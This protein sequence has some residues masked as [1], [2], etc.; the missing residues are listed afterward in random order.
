M[1]GRLII[2]HI[3]DKIPWLHRTILGTKISV[4]IKIYK[5]MLTLLHIGKKAI[6]ICWVSCKRRTW[7]KVF[8]RK[9]M[10]N[11]FIFP[12]EDEVCKKWKE[13]DLCLQSCWTCPTH[14][15]S[16]WN[17]SHFSR[18]FRRTTRQRAAT[19]LFRSYIHTLE[20]VQWLD[21]ISGIQTKGQHDPRGIT[22]K[23]NRCPVLKTHT[24]M[25]CTLEV[26]VT[27]NFIE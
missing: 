5:G 27:R 12:N 24:L 2:P 15:D 11:D 3:P 6:I 16:K 14:D 4:K 8:S 18:I 1:F 20:P 23:V 22:A 21:F 10:S 17:K 7:L 9:K 13:K 25:L 26:E 19:R